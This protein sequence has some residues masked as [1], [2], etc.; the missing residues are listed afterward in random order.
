M[1]KNQAVQQINDIY[2]LIEGNLRTIIPWQTMLFTGLGVMA[3]PLIEY[4]LNMFIDPI[5]YGY[6]QH[7]AVIFLLRTVFYWALF[8]GIA[9]YTKK[10]KKNRLLEKVFSI[11]R[12]FPIIPVT[13]AAALAYAGYS[14]L[15]SPM[16]LILVGCL[17]ALYGQFS[18]CIMRVVAW[19]N[20]LGGII[21]ILLAPCFGAHL[22]SYLVCYQGLTMVIMGIILWYTQEQPTDY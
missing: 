10:P 9:Q 7:N 15:I 16:V 14:D 17:F 18:S 22:W 20:I 5:I 13:T 1:D 6:P 19:A 3:I 4:L 2:T 11:G 12:L 8:F 21:G